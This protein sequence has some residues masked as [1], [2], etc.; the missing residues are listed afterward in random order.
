LLVLA[1]KPAITRLTLGG[2]A[3]LGTSGA[4]WACSD[5]Q[6]PAFIGTGSDSSFA[7]VSSDVR[8]VVDSSDER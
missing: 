8:D 2:V 1:C 4:F 5:D 7:Y 3:L 6:M